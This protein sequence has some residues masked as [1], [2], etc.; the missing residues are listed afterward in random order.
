[1]ITAGRIRWRGSANRRF[2]FPAAS[3]AA[4]ASPQAGLATVFASLRPFPPR[5]RSEPGPPKAA[6]SAIP[7]ASTQGPRP[8]GGAGFDADGAANVKCRAPEPAR[9]PSASR[10]LPVPNLRGRLS[11]S[12]RCDAA[13]CANKTAAGSREPNG[14]RKTLKPSDDSTAAAGK[15]SVPLAIEPAEQC[16]RGLGG[17]LDRL[18]GDPLFFPGMIE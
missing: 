8:G 13:G 14:Q 4:L 16:E 9:P 7:R 15:L 1:M 10:V 6:C 2:K 18:P 17:P 12:R 11:S 3:H 5:R